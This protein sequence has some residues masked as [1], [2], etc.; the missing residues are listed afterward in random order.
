MAI[1]VVEHID[2]L[3]DFL[4]SVSNHL[5]SH[6]KFIVEILQRGVYVVARLAINYRDWILA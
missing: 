5:E 2:E 4:I 6:G 3:D 1:A